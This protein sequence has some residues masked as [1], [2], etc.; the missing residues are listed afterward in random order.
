MVPN[1]TGT[2]T[3]A[4]RQ[5]EELPIRQMELP[6]PVVSDAIIEEIRQNEVLGFRPLDATFP[7]SGG[8]D[9]LRAARDAYWAEQ[10]DIQ[11]Q[12]ANAWVLQ[13]EGKPDEALVKMAK[14][15]AVI[16]R[17]EALYPR[18]SQPPPP[19]ACHKRTPEHPATPSAPCLPESY[20]RRPILRRWGKCGQCA[21]ASPTSAPPPATDSYSGRHRHPQSDLFRS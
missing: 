10:V 11:W 16:A 7:L 17:I 18:R 3:G 15:G 5:E 1:A 20:Q 8:A 2:L 4:A 13:A 9:A 21:L 19:T 12:I 14:L 6:S